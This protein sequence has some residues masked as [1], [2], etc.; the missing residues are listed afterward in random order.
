MLFFLSW[1]LVLALLVVAPPPPPPY[2]PSPFDGLP[3]ELVQKVSESMTSQDLD[4]WI[5]S[6]T[7]L[8]TTSENIMLYHMLHSNKPPFDPWENEADHKLGL[9]YPNAYRKFLD[10][11]LI[12]AELP[13]LFKLAILH[14]RLELVQH[15]IIKGLDPSDEDNYAICYASELGHLPIVDLLLLDPRVNASARNNYA[16]A[17]ASRNGHV[18]VVARLLGHGLASSAESMNGALEMACANGHLEILNML[19]DHRPV[20]ALD[21]NLMLVACRNGHLPILDRLL[22]TGKMDPSCQKNYPIIL[23]SS[24]GHFA[25]VDRLLQEDLRVWVN[26]ADRN[27]KAISEACAH[28]HH[29]VVERLLQDPRVDP[30]VHDHEAIISSLN[31]GDC[32]LFDLLKQYYVSNGINLPPFE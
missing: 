8:N 12:R 23:A 19:L 28:G 25:V 5:Q 21:E 29:A 1:G 7:R 16:L 2:F 18:Q 11:S 31:T 26:P 17:Q 6:S 22:E 15:A 13:S 27:N 4:S 30:T 24:H 10:H 32:L 20:V 3:M 14:G 9:K